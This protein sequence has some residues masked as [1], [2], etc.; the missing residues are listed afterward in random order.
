[1]IIPSKQVRHVC[2]HVCCGR[3]SYA[4]RI[5]RGC[6]CRMRRANVRLLHRAR[7]AARAAHSNVAPARHM[8]RM[9][10]VYVR[11]KLFTRYRHV[12]TAMKTRLR[13][14]TREV[15]LA[16]SSCQLLNGVS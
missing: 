6:V 2:V 13:A 16:S 15:T 12:P 7:A 11:R 3:I 8:P 1:M 14:R 9:V 4:T 5:R 10:A